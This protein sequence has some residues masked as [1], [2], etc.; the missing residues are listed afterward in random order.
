MSEKT[1]KPDNESLR[2]MACE[3]ELYAERGASP[4]EQV[5]RRWAEIM[6]EATDKQC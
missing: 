5:L 3:M 6:R 4:D 2:V 1:E